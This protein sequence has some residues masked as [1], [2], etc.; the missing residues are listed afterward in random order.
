[1][2]DLPAWLPS[3]P[4][5]EV[6]SL[7][8]ARRARG[9]EMERRILDA[10]RVT[11]RKYGHERARVDDIVEQAGVSHGA[12]YRYFRNKEDLLH[13]MAVECAARL[14]VLTAE[15]DSMRRPVDQEEFGGWIKRFGAAY[16][17]DGPVIRVWMDNRDTDPLM[18]A[19]A[20]DSLGPLAAALARLA[21]PAISAAAGE[22]M[23]GL[24]ML[25]L[26]ERLNSYFADIDHDAVTATATRLLFGATVHPDPS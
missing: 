18:Q 9:E 13:R 6:T 20:N 1:M 3:T 14:R 17:D 12:F 8:G 15:L 22:A 23:T 21:D 24:G 26:L 10:G 25:S 16:Q 11:F 7:S 2:P 5:T 4:A 19:L